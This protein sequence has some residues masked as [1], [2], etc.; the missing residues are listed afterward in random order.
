[1][2]MQNIRKENN[3]SKMNKKTKKNHLIGLLF[4]SPAILGFLIFTL[5]PMLASLYFSFTEYNGFTIPTFIGI[6]NYKEMFSGADP[7]FFKSLKVTLY[8]ILLSVPASIIFSLLMAMLLNINVKGKVLFRAI[9][10][11]PSIVPVVATAMIWLWLFNPEFGLVNNM[12]EAI[13]LPTSY[14]LYSEK[15]VIPT[16]VIMGLWGTGNTVVI[17]LAGL[18]GIPRQYYEA[19]EVDGG[20]A[21]HKLLHITLP[22]LTPTIFFNLV[23]GLIG[24]FQVFTQAYI[25]TRGGPNNASLFYVYHLYRNA[26][27]YSRMG[28][29]CALAWLLFVIILI[30]TI[31]SFKTSG[32]WVF[33]EGGKNE[34]KTS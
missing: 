33:Y 12:L 29:A 14:W 21:F 13:G 16:I 28:Y 4:A 20:N 27:S 7:F 15:T 31:I 6:N 19:I 23:M 26:F 2:K 10:Y 32:Y 9:F 22:L 24:G 1:M 17:F 34:N 18:Q 11:L 8:F 30:F 5:T 25:L 3:G